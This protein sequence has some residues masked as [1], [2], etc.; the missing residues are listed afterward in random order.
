MIENISTIHVYLAPITTV[1][2]LK[3]HEKDL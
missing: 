2:A 3:F 1:T